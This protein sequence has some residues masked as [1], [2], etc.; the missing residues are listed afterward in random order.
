[1]QITDE[2]NETWDLFR[3]Y[4]VIYLFIYISLNIPSSL[5][6]ELIILLN[7]NLKTSSYA[8]VLLLKMMIISELLFMKPLRLDLKVVNNLGLV[9]QVVER[10]IMILKLHMLKICINLN[11]KVALS[12]LK[13]LSEL[14][15]LILILI[16][17]KKNRI[18]KLPFLKK[19]ILKF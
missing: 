14:L 8:T 3:S 6:L 9:T 17:K 11:I 10:K 2:Y 4:V 18:K 13:L 5:E 19:F 15:K 7:K 16:N 12:H 1:M